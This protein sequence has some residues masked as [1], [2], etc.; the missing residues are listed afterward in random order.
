MT[1]SQWLRKRLEE[2]LYGKCGDKTESLD[3]LRQTEWSLLF[4]TLMRNRLLMGRFRYGKMGDPQKGDYDCISSAITRLRL[5][6]QTGNL[7][8][9]PDVANLCLVEFVHSKHPKKHFA[10][11][12][13]GIHCERNDR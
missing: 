5:Y 2:K 6:Q 3:S 10:A 11:H 8:H 7:E 9:L 13:D 1:N 4:E 12:D